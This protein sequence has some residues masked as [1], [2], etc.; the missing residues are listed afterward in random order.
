[1]FYLLRVDGAI[2]NRLVRTSN[3]T[4][5]FASICDLRSKSHIFSVCPINCHKITIS[6]SFKINGRKLICIIGNSVITSSCQFFF[7][8][9]R[10]KRCASFFKISVLY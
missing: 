1:M 10:I 7:I 6:F 9:I 8:V 5:L 2:T 3:T 4:I